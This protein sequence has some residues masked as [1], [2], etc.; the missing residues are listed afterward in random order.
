MLVSG[1]DSTSPDGTERGAAWPGAAATWAR[2]TSSA[3]IRPSGPVPRSDDSSIPRS[4]AI[5]RA[6]GEALM[7]AP[8]VSTAAAGGAEEVSDTAGV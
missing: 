8:F 1:T 4:R 3:T 6:S 2:S 7:R 5:R